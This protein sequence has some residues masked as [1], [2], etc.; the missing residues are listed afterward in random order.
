MDGWWLALQIGVFGLALWL[1]L[2]LIGRDLKSVRLR[3]AGLGL[4]SYGVGWGLELLGQAATTELAREIAR[5]RWP[6]FFLPALFWTGAIIYLLPTDKPWQATLARVWRNGLL[7]VALLFYL[8]AA[9]TNQLF[10]SQGNRPSSGLAYAVF[11]LLI[12]LPLLGAL[13]LVWQVYRASRLSN[14]TGVL[15]VGI[16][17]FSLSSGLLIFPLDW[18]SRPVMLG[19]VGFDLGLLG[20]GIALWD[21]FDQ[22]EAFL[23]DFVRS[24]D[25]AFFT[26]VLFGGQVALVMLLA[27]GVTFAMLAL[28]LA[29]VGTAIAAQ[30]FAAQVGTALDRL[31]LARFPRLRQARADLR[32]AASVLPRV[33]EGVELE[34]LDEIEFTRLTRR[35]FS[36]FGDLPRLAVSPLIYLPLVETRLARRGATKADPLE[37]AVELKAVL[38]ESVLRLKPRGK[39]DFGT[40]DEW[41]HFNALYFPYIMGLKPYS[42]RTQNGPSDPTTHTALEW[43]RDNVP[44][45]TLYNWQTA[46]T[47]LVAHD[48]RQPRERE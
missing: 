44:E 29:T 40:A 20:V 2:Y 30:V 7:P 31:A 18:L 17:F 23:P 46:A 22:G 3:L 42:R 25:Y 33:N 11:I 21:A 15:L 47:K 19:S 48:L 34:G 35:A 43:F 28:L 36:S 13:L 37:R 10:D 26:V 14:G 38:T 41:R 32:I 1:G 39:G 24:F 12:I 45:R 5:W 8:V 6:F 27:T 9:A 4:V 16:L